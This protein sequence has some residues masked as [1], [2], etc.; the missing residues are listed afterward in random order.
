M[1]VFTV[2]C[3][4]LMMFLLV[5]DVYDYTRLYSRLILIQDRLSHADNVINSYAITLVRS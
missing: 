4:F 1:Q 3:I 2:V 5:F